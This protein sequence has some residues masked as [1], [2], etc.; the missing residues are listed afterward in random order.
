MS[1]LGHC[2]VPC[3]SNSCTVI[4]HALL[5]QQDFDDKHVHYRDASATAHPGP[6]HTSSLHA[7]RHTPDDS[8]EKKRKSRNM[9]GSEGGWSVAV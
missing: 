8:K 1:A 6:A 2:R 3:S 7:T 5:S 4:T 9:K